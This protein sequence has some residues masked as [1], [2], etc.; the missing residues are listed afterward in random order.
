MES[1]VEKM[2]AGE[3]YHQ[4]DELLQ[5]RLNLRDK[6][7]EYNHCHPREIEKRERF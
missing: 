6:L 2:I 5:I 3:L 4:T 7:Y 1:E